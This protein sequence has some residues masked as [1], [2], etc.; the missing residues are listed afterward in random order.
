MLALVQH[1]GKQ[2]V[3]TFFCTHYNS[4]QHFHLEHVVLLAACLSPGSGL[5]NSLEERR[6]EEGKAAVHWYSFETVIR[7]RHCN[8]HCSLYL[9]FTVWSWC[10]FLALFPATPESHSLW[11]EQ[12]GFYDLL[13][14][15]ISVTFSVLPG[16][17]P[18]WTYL[19]VVKV[20]VGG[21]I[22]SHEIV[23]WLIP[24][25]EPQSVRPR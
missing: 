5:Y 22:S 6:G 25:L 23:W 20:N 1:E 14:V 10:F 21:S 24:D 8:Q 18:L 11:L 19:C 13:E 12:F 17:W 2:T 7:C 15:S 16:L 4:S 3:F 9:P